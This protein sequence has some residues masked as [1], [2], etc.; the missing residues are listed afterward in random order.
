MKLLTKLSAVMLSAA[1]AAGAVSLNTAAL[2]IIDVYD[3]TADDT[4]DNS[5]EN[6]TIEKKQYTLTSEFASFSIT[7]PEEL[8][9][10][11]LTSMS[12]E[13]KD[14]VTEYSLFMSG[15]DNMTI[16]SAYHIS[17]GGLSAEM[18]KWKELDDI[19]IFED[20]DA[21]GNP[22]Y[23]VKLSIMTDYYYIGEYDLGD[24]AWVN[25]SVSGSLI[26]DN[27]EL[28]FEVLRSYDIS[29]ATDTPRIEGDLKEVG[30]IGDYSF[31]A[32]RISYESEKC[33]L[34]VDIPADFA[35]QVSAENAFQSDDGLVY[36]LFTALRNSDV[37]SATLIECDGGAQSREEFWADYTPNTD[38][39]GNDF[40]SYMESTA[41]HVLFHA[42]YPN[43]DNSYIV[44]EFSFESKIDMETA[45][46]IFYAL[47]SFSKD[48][49]ASES[50]KEVV[51]K[52]FA[53]EGDGL[54]FSIDV[55]EEVYS[56]IENGKYYQ[57]GFV[58]SDGAD[59]IL[60][61]DL[62]TGSYE[63]EIELWNSADYVVN[64][65]TDSDGNEFTLVEM[66]DNKILAVYNYGDNQVLTICTELISAE[67]FTIMAESLSL[68]VD[69]ANAN[70]EKGSP[71]TGVEMLPLAV[72][73]LAGLALAISRKKK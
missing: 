33:S 72:P 40:Y 37:I 39:N 47:F 58:A 52:R 43:D 22:F 63:S 6:T 42:E 62:L 45:D 34:S 60:Q 1:V 21:L 59:V 41:N 73:A 16:S 71:D 54:S 50:E 27:P 68:A 4:T 61:A 32:K 51:M 20:T 19:E 67:T 29:A 36:P 55:P 17:D 26:A 30:A 48:P 35:P 5:A 10:E 69:N 31:D 70:A 44:V 11:L 53:C 23:I 46:N 49:L 15:S 25:I 66:P 28:A 14:D 9:I 64:T 18:E 13:T 56:L 7:I 65:H 38:L 3:D 8:T 24:G 57:N 12:P 2:N